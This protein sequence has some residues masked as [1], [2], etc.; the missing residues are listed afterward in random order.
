MFNNYIYIYFIINLFIYVN[1]LYNKS[2]LYYVSQYLYLSMLISLCLSLYIVIIGNYNDPGFLITEYTFKTSLLDLYVISII[3]AC[4]ITFYSIVNRLNVIIL[5][6]SCIC[7]FTFIIL[8]G[9]YFINFDKYT[10]AN[11]IYIFLASAMCVSFL[12]AFINICITYEHERAILQSIRSF[13]QYISNQPDNSN[14]NINNIN[15]KN[16]YCSNKTNSSIFYNDIN[17]NNSL[18]EDLL[19]E[20]DIEDQVC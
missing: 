20:G 18:D 3:T 15:R 13:S 11:Y 9:Y 16:S 5:T 19:Y 14:N 6:I 4:F 10:T 2:L 7:I 12:A 8:K 17:Y 1:Y